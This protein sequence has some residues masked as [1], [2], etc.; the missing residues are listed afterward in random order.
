MDVGEGATTVLPQIA[1]E[2]LGADTSRSKRYSPTVAALPTRP[3]PQAPPP[4]SPPAPPSSRPPTKCASRCWRLPLRASK[5]PFTTSTPRRVGSTSSPTPSRRMA[6]A[7][8]ASRMDG[9][10]LSATASHHSRKLQPHRKLL[11]C[12]LRRG[13]GDTDTGRVRV[14]RYVAAHDSGRI[15]NPRAA[16][17]QAEGAISQML[18]FALSEELVTDA[19]TGVTLNPPATSSTS[20]PP[21][22]LPRRPDNLRRHRGPGRPPRSQGP[23]RSPHRRPGPGHSQRHLQRHRSPPAPHS[24]HA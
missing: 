7:E 21:S 8:V 13:G 2:I 1:A 15:I 6:L 4:P 16:L 11:R 24:L 18:G 17:N 12:P 22:R 23:R 10:E 14:L 3:S 5:F 20:R 19:A 9:D